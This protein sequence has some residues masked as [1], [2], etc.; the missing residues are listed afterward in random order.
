MAVSVCIN[1]IICQKVPILLL[2][3]NFCCFSPLDGM[4]KTLSIFC[5]KDNRVIIKIFVLFQFCGFILFYFFFVWI[6]TTLFWRFLPLLSLL[7]FQYLFLPWL[8]KK[9]YF[10]FINI[11]ENHLGRNYIWYICSVNDEDFVSPSVF[12]SIKHLHNIALRENWF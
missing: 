2:T 7:V 3:F 4:D 11:W 10:F 5:N 8:K 9:I 12:N 6:M 1:W